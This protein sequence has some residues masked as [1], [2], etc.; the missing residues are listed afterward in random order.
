MTRRLRVIALQGLVAVVAG[1]GLTFL[2]AVGRVPEFALNPGMSVLAAAFFGRGRLERCSF[3]G[4][5]IGRGRPGGVGRILLEAG[6]KFGEALFVVL[7]R[8]PDSGLSSRWDMLPE[9][10][11]YW[12]TRAHAAGL[13]I[14]LRLGNVDP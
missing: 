7:D 6:F 11:R 4:G 3:E 12:W 14:D 5:G 10:V 8:C 9:F 13:A 1:R 2:H